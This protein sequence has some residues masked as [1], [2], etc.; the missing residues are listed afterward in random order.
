MRRLLIFLV[1]Y[2]SNLELHLILP[3]Y[4]IHTQYVVLDD[5]LLLAG[6]RVY[7]TEFLGV[8]YLMQRRVDRAPSCEGT[9]CLGLPLLTPCYKLRLLYVLHS[10]GLV[11][12][13]EG[14][15]RAV[16]SMNH[17]VLHEVRQTRGASL[18][19]PVL[20]HCNGLS[21]TYGLDGWPRLVDAL[22]VAYLLEGL[23][24]CIVVFLN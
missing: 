21:A 20:L 4:R 15:V 24:Q 6:H 12:H 14:G 17:E 22:E 7:I 3:Q 19:L 1:R 10:R 9:I 18:V 5:S 16:E 23:E 11:A 8:K 13:E 2:L